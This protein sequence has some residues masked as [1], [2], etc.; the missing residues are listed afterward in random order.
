MRWNY[1]I[2][3][4][5]FVCGIS[6]SFGWIHDAKV[7]GLDLVNANVLPVNYLFFQLTDVYGRK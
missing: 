5:L 7:F 4:L 1:G 2:V 6:S 3:A